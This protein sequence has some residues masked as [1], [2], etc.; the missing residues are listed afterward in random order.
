FYF[1][2]EDHTNL[3]DTFSELEV[4][5]IC[6]VLYTKD[7]IDKIQEAL[8][9]ILGNQIT[10]NVVHGRDIGD[11]A[12][13]GS[14]TKINQHEKSI[15]M[16]LLLDEFA[17]SDLYDHLSYSGAYTKYKDENEI[18]KMNLVARYQSL[19]KKSFSFLTCSTKLEEHCK[20]FN[21]IL[22]LADK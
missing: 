8:Q 12:F 19:P 4:L 1:T 18:N 10:V 14:T 16:D 7:A 20:P 6:T 22:E 13:F 21:R 11:N 17:L 2:D 5:N 9:I 15:I 3:F